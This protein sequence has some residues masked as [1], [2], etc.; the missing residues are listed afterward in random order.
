[1]LARVQAYVQRAHVAERCTDRN[2]EQRCRIWIGRSL[3][4]DS[5][6]HHRCRIIGLEQRCGTEYGRVHMKKKIFGN[7]RFMAKRISPS[8]ES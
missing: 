4:S 8:T 2:I 1:M 7:I 5:K 3:N 6:I